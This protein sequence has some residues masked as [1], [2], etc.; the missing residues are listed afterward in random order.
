MRGDL[1][2]YRAKKGDFAD[3]LISHFTNGPFVHVEIDL[4]DGQ[5]IGEHGAGIEV[6][7]QDIIDPTLFVTPKSTLGEDGIRQ[8]M[9]FVV[10]VANEDMKDPHSHRYGWFDIVSDVLKIMGSKIILRKEGRWDCSHFAALYLIAAHADKPLGITAKTPE[11]I[12]P[13]DLAR[14]FGIIK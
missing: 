10:R 1:V 12:S 13:N 6:H 14:D 5:F 11:T 9:D 7:P 4:G 2:F 3:W 8:G